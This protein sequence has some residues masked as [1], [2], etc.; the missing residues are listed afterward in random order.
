MQPEADP[1]RRTDGREA[2]D[3]LSAIRR[4][5]ATEP[6][7][8]AAPARPTTLVLT[9]AQRVRPPANNGWRTRRPPAPRAPADPRARLESSISEMA[10][11]MADLMA[12]AATAARPKRG[13]KQ[14]GARSDAEAEEL[15]DLVAEVV[16]EELNGA[17]G[18]RLTRNV[19]KLVRA[20]I[21][22]TLAA[23]DLQR[24]PA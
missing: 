24:E 9:A 18:E 8:P 3:V 21:A 4:L 20:E 22:R 11:A 14:G 12:G 15:R 2:E 16:R 5:V 13:G 7:R 23:R 1:S 17:L 19:R 6:A 10:S